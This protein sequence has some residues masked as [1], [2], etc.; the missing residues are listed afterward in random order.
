MM[1]TR[2]MQV[3]TLSIPLSLMLIGIIAGVWALLYILGAVLAYL[4]GHPD[5]S[6]FTTYLSD[7]G[8]T[9]GWPG[10]I[11]NSGTLITVPIRYLVLVLLAL[12]LEQLGAGRAFMIATLIIGFLTAAGT[13]LMTAV[14]YTVSLGVHKA[15]IGLYFLGVVV[16]QT[17]ICIREWSLKGVPIILPVLSLL[18]VVLY[19]VF[20]AF[21]VLY[22]RGTV[23]RTVPVIWEWLSILSSIVWML[24]QS[25]LLGRA[26]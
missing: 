24:F 10:I 21:F 3:S 4:P 1:F 11:F 7:M 16:L 2:T 17:V 9:P 13:A 20:L 6:P 14:P 8:A 26:N 12:R 22:E 25:I 19:L 5:F 23:G 15:G 18:M